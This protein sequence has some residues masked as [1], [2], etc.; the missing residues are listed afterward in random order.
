MQTLSL[1]SET[2]KRLQRKQ[3]GRTILFDKNF[4]NAATWFHWEI[5]LEWCY[6][7][8]TPSSDPRLSHRFSYILSHLHSLTISHTLTFCLMFSNTPLHSPS[9][10]SW[11]SSLN[12]MNSN[13]S[14]ITLHMPISLWLK[15]WI[16][17]SVGRGSCSPAQEPLGNSLRSRYAL[18]MIPLCSCYALVMHFCSVHHLRT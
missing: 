4:S 13:R 10:D 1:Q 14:E 9:V 15:V 17:K 6:K 16:S 5:H 18:V 3:F 12:L 7:L 8:Q 2:L 11:S